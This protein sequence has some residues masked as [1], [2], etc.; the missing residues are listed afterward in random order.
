[1]SHI[2]PLNGLP[3][4]CTLTPTAGQAQVE[5]WQAFDDDYALSSD[6]TNG[7]L[8]IQYTKVEDSITRLRELVAAESACCSFVNWSIDDSPTDLRLII[9]GTEEQLAALTITPNPA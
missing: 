6:R 7:R 9:T 4:T 1:M 2:G 3:I 8:V 5:A